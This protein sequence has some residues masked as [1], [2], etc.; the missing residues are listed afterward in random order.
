MHDIW[1]TTAS[2]DHVHYRALDQEGSWT[3][4]EPES[5]SKQSWTQENIR[6]RSTQNTAFLE[7]PWTV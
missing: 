7:K 5:K 4:E 3:L 6:P 1:G 2:D